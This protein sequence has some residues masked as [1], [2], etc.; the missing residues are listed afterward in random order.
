MLSIYFHKI[1]QEV[2]MKNEYNGH[3]IYPKI[4][5][6][7]KGSDLLISLQA[8]AK[9]ENKAGYILSIVGNLSKAKI[10]CPGKQ[11]STLIK[12]TLEIISLNGTIDPNH[13]H[14]HISFS[15]GNCNMWAGHLEE[16]TIILKTADMLIGFLDENLIKKEKNIHNKQVQIYIIPD[17]P[18]SA[19]A[20][21]ML[22]TLQV[23]HEIIVIKNDNDFKSLNKMTKYNSFPQIFINGEFIGGYSELAELHSSGKLIK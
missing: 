21:R 10:Q 16:G 6:L 18:W 1:N 22:R 19:R 13:C 2:N 8:I 17:C 20:I 15:D 5:K 4:L 7:E 11:H 23:E 12:N 3:V 14:L 9:K